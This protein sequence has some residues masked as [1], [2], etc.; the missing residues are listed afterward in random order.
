MI[1]KLEIFGTE[2]SV[3]TTREGQWTVKD[4]TTHLT[5]IVT[6]DG[7]KIKLGLVFEKTKLFE[8]SANPK[9]NVCPICNG[10]GRL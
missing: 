5:Y 7:D 4:H 8:A 1:I 3:D 9:G 6:N 2:I 10:S